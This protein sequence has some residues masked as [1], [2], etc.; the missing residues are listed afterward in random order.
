MRRFECYNKNSCLFYYINKSLLPE[1]FPSQ[2][3]S[4]PIDI[5]RKNYFS[6]GKPTVMIRLQ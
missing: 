5:I 6:S 4:F 1:Y 2:L 3:S